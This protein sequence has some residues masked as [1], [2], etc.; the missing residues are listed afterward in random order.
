VVLPERIAD[1]ANLITADLLYLTRLGIEPAG[2]ELTNEPQGAWDLKYEPEQYAELV[3]RARQA[4]DAAGLQRVRID[5][6]GTGLRNFKAFAK[7][8]KSRNAMPALGWLT[9]HAYQSPEALANNDT[10]GVEEFL[11]RGQLGPIIITEFG[12]K[13][14]NADDE[15]A[16]ARDVD[17]DSSEYALQTA[18]ESL[19]LL[20]KGAT[21]VIYWQLEDFNWSKKKHG[22]LDENSRRRPVAAA[23][24]ALF[25]KV[26]GSGSLVA[27]TGG[28][29]TVP[30]EALQAD[31][32]VYVL[33]VNTTAQPQ[34]VTAHFSGVAPRRSVGAASGFVDRA[35]SSSAL[36]GVTLKDGVLRATLAPRSAASVELQ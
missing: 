19:M 3:L 30:A 14:H 1:W 13:K 34:Q 31:G 16:A 20:G 5:G 12:V 36:T 33:L 7:G 32:R 27:G 29:A 17:V 28:P 2:V 23:V 21:S 15:E 10:P 35:L 9:A 26:P 25:G 4:M 11:G 22:M 8:L 24:Q 18:A 6:P